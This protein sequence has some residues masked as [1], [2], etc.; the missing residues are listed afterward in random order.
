M[1][2]V[3]VTMDPLRPVM[4]TDVWTKLEKIFSDSTNIETGSLE[5]SVQGREMKNGHF[6]GIYCLLGIHTS[7]ALP[8]QSFECLLGCK[9]QWE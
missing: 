4:E 1:A 7:K 9:S 2:A 3:K 8:I 5:C 6:T